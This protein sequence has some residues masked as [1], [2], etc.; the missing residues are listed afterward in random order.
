MNKAAA[1]RSSQ[2]CHKLEGSD[3]LLNKNGEKRKEAFR[4]RGS[5]SK[6]SASVF[7]GVYVD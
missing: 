4:H 7:C 3:D 1:F 5:Q 6:G 2:V